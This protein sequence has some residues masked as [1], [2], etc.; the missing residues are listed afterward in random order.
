MH[1]YDLIAPF[2]DIE[3][4][5]FC[6]DLDMYRNF[7]EVCG[8]QILELACGSGRVLLSLAHEGY[9]LTGVDTSIS[10]L[11]IAR[12]RLEK[13]GVAHR[14]KVVEQDI[15][16]LDLR[17]KFRMAFIALGSFGHITTRSQQK[18]ALAAVRS[19][20]S[21]GGLFIL[22]ISNTDARYLERLGG[23]TLHQGTWHYEDG[24]LLTHFISPATSP[25]QHLLEITHFYDR[26]SQGGTVQRTTVTTHLYL[27]ERNEIE[28]LLEQAGFT[29][30]DIYGNYDL[31]AYQLDS[32]RMI[33]IA[34][35]R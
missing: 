3:H 15:C 17:Q 29:I 20:L 2:Y 21:Y 31:S 4:A 18:Q 22:D 28:L 34:E 25:E 6:E 14:C 13:E 23:Y 30:K 1:D 5:H 9:E 16:T 12:Q 26:Y 24:T 33:C 35:A 27:F 7:A 19:H 11:E 32:P 10:M 8:G